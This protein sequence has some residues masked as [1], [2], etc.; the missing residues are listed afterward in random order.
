MR[1][2]ADSL[3]LFIECRFF[4]VASLRCTKNIN[5]SP[6]GCQWP[7]IAI[8]ISHLTFGGK[9]VPLNIRGRIKNVAG[10]LQAYP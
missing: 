8:A 4:A 10:A 7:P 2:K 1:V 3:G 5:R 9:T 6:T